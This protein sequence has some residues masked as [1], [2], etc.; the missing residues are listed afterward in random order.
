MEL[1]RRP[2]PHGCISGRG[3]AGNLSAR[4]QMSCQ[5][6]PMERTIEPSARARSCWLACMFQFACNF[7]EEE[8]DGIWLDMNEATNFCDGYCIEEERPKNSLRNK[9]YY[10]PGQRDLES[11]SL[12]VDGRH[13]NGF[14]EYDTHNTF[15]LI[16]CCVLVNPFSKT[17]INGFCA[18]SSPDLNRKCFAFQIIPV[19]NSGLSSSI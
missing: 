9:P 3:W 12:G 6:E 15:S 1:P 19:E 13:D 17:S 2:H 8:L 7:E 4:A 5:T 16:C 18:A 14:R 10:V 11:E